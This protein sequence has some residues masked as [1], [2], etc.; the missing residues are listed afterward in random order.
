MLCYS[1]EKCPPGSEIYAYL[2]AGSSATNLDIAVRRFP[3]GTFP[4][5][6]NNTQNGVRK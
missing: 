6:E 1:I 2:R 4:E 3:K 5:L